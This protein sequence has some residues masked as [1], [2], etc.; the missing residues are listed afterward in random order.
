MPTHYPGTAREKRALDAFIKLMRATES[1]AARIGHSI[2]EG[3]L[4]YGQVS[5][6]EALHHLG[7]MHACDLGKK[8]L[9]SN[10]NMTT[11]LDNLEKAGLVARER[12]REDRRFVLVSLTPEGKRRIASA[13]PTHV[14]EITDALSALG[15]AEQDELG[16]LCKKLGLAQAGKETS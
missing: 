9:R 11:V 13:L 4:T 1:V 8:L 6:L 3:G 14:G 12:T 7:P 5:V 15:A 2:H 10:A 16:R